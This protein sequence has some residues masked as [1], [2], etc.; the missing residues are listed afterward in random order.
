MRWRVVGMVRR[1]VCTACRK[2]FKNGAACKRC[3]TYTMPIEL[4][5]SAFYPLMLLFAAI[6]VAAIVLTFFS[7]YPLMFLFMFPLIAVAAAFD[8]ADEHVISKNAVKAALSMQ[9]APRSPMM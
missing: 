2:A 5:H 6:S 1:F 7:I 8:L 4:G 3:G 9:Q